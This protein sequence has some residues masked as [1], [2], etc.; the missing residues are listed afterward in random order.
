MTKENDFWKIRLKK[1]TELDKPSRISEILFGLIMVLTFT[2]TISV[3]TAGKQEVKELLWAALG[4]NIA[5]GV[6]DGIMYLMDVLIDRSYRV[7]ELNRIKRSQ[8]K[9]ES[10][11]IVRENL[12][13]LVADLME[14][15]D[16]DRLSEKLKNLPELSVR[17]TFIFKDFVIAG[18][19]FMLVFLVTLPVALPFLF[20]DRVALAMRVSNGIALFLL[21]AGG[22][23]LA[24][25]SG[26]RPVITA[27][28]YTAIGVLLVALTMVLGG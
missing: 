22:F 12:S 5:W 9:A 25:Y 14:D 13:P 8:N 21:F 23:S 19:I 20:F 17:K 16:I 3:S 24:R 26:L 27:L 15:E 4:C 6:V 1:W 10:R 7:K 2:G 11:D 28:T 18:Q